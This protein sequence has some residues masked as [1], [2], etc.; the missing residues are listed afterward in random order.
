M[1]TWQSEW[2]YLCIGK[3]AFTS[4]VWWKAKENYSK[5]PQTQLYTLKEHLGNEKE[6]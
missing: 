5:A 2:K 4:K 6:I 3:S 1:E